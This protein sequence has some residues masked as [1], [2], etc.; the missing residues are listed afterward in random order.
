MLGLF[1][2][3]GHAQLALIFDYFYG[4]KEIFLVIY[5]RALPFII[6]TKYTFYLKQDCD[7]QSDMTDSPSTEQASWNYLV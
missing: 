5:I 6:Y 3:Y 4:R 7:L 1:T 2:S